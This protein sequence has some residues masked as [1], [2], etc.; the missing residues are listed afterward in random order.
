MD[1]SW[2]LAAVYFIIFAIWVT[3]T[4]TQ[5]RHETKGKNLSG[6]PEDNSK[7]HP[8]LLQKLYTE[9]SRCVNHL[10]TVVLPHSWNS[11]SRP[12]WGKCT[13]TLQCCPVEWPDR[14]PTPG[15]TKGCPR[16]A[17]AICTGGEKLLGRGEQHEV[18]KW[19]VWIDNRCEREADIC[20][21]QFFQFSHFSLQQ[22][23]TVKTQQHLFKM[24]INFNFWKWERILNNEN[25]FKE[26]LKPDWLSIF[27]R[28]YIVSSSNRYEPD[29]ATSDSNSAKCCLYIV[30]IYITSSNA[31]V[32][33]MLE[34]V[35][36][37]SGGTLTLPT[38]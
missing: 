10:A 23:C 3:G 31:S 19:A 11:R 33:K 32:D 26:P 24:K 7:L 17:W 14:L 21:W 8:V 5:N 20:A 36:S 37:R 38:I 29:V 12:A 27:L 4:S 18:S 16:P 25:V 22:S 34:H 30:I 6:A 35:L 1:Q 13:S 9:L 2:L 15:R 28:D